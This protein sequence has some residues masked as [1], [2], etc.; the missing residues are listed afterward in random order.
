MSTTAWTP[1]LALF[2]LAGQ[3]AAAEV[4]EQSKDHFV[5]RASATVTASPRETWLA[6]IQPAK[7]WSKAH[8]WSGD[9]AN[10]SLTPQG[11]GCFCE[12]IPEQDSPREVGLAGSVQHMVVVQAQPMEV[13]RLRGG[14]GP[15]Q[16]EPAEGV[17]TIA[18]QP[19]D[20]GT[21]VVWEYVVAGHMR[22]EIPVIAKAV[23]GVMT[24]Q[25]GRL[26]DLLGRADEPASAAADKPGSESFEPARDE[27]A[28]VED[29]IDRMG[30]GKPAK[31]D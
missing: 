7:W 13:L 29:A 23:D 26:A 19:V 18:M 28:D 1:I 2:A 27:P 14:L 17:L 15:L 25:L 16:S 20:G 21:K 3:P 12:R 8:T 22:Y 31:G 6:L 9:A 10:L 24:E 30:E 5:T 4:V 11:G